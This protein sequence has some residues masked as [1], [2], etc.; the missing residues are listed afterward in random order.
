MNNT[1]NMHVTFETHVLQEILYFD[2]DFT[3]VVRKS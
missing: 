1:G 2:L 3:E